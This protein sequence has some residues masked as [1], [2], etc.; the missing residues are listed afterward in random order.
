[1]RT[2]MERTENMPMPNL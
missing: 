1:M 2:P